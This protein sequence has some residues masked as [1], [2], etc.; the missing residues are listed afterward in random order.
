MSNISLTERK[1]RNDIIYLQRKP[2]DRT[3]D[4]TKEDVDESYSER[5][6]GARGLSD[7][8][9]STLRTRNLYF[10]FCQACLTRRETQGKASDGEALAAVTSRPK[11]RSF[12][13]KKP[14]RRV[15]NPRKLGI[16]KRRNLTDELVFSNVEAESHP[17]YIDFES[18]LALSDDFLFLDSPAFEIFLLSHLSSFFPSWKVFLSCGF[19][20]NFWNSWWGFPRWAFPSFIRL[21][22]GI[23]RSFLSNFYLLPVLD[24]SWWSPPRVLPFEL[25]HVFFHSIVSQRWQLAKTP[26]FSLQS[27]SRLLFERVEQPWMVG[28]TIRLGR[29]FFKQGLSR[30]SSPLLGMMH[31]YGYE[32]SLLSSFLTW[33]WKS[34]T[35]PR[36]KA[37]LWMD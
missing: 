31:G 24:L 2:P 22:N 23:G 10:W 14:Y 6:R 33:I 32:C 18:S 8:F 28:A 16:L 30:K 13:K 7:F 35:N 15:R 20:S 21:N 36:I 12:S 3:Q 27:I 5:Y 34:H 26:Y 25:L 1:T 37:F 19:L 9:V 11:R 29:I 17:D 4:G